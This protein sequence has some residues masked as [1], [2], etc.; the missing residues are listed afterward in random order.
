MATVYF[1]SGG[2]NKYHYMDP[3]QLFSLFFLFL[4][5]PVN[6]LVGPSGPDKDKIIILKSLKEVSP[7]EQY[8]HN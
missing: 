8:V 7:I 2:L 3:S 4:L 1:N 5:L 6:A